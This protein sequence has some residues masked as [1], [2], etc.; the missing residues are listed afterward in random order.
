MFKNYI[1]IAIRNIIKQKLYSFINITGLMVGIA[2]SILIMLYVWQELS[3]DRF[4]TKA[5]QIYRVVIENPHLNSNGE[6]REFKRGTTGTGLALVLKEEFP[7]ILH[8][9]RL[10]PAYP[11]WTFTYNGKMIYEKHRSVMWVDPSFVD[12]FDISWI[13]GDQ[14]TALNEPQSIV[15]TEE[16]AL[17]YFGEED[18]LGKI[19]NLKSGGLSRDYKVT[20]VAKAMPDNSHFNFNFITNDPLWGYDPPFYSWSET[21]TYITLPKGYDPED[22]ETKLPLIVNKYIVP[23]LASNMTMTWDKYVE[24]GVYTKLHLQ[25]LKDIYLGSYFDSYSR[26]G[27]ITY[28][29]IFSTIAFLILFLA[30]VNFMTLSTAR[31]SSRAKEVGVRKILGSSRG[32]LIRQ[33]LSE[34]I[35]NTI[36]A[37]VGALI[38][39]KLFLPAFNN[40]LGM[41]ITP[42]FSEIGLILFTPLAIVIMVGILAGSYPAFFLSVFHPPTFLKGTLPERSR[43]LTLRNSMVVF[44]FIISIV[45][46][47]ASI[48]VYNQL[49]YMRKKDPGYNKK[50]IIIIDNLQEIIKQDHEGMEE[51]RK[52]YYKNYNEMARDKRRMYF[53]LRP[54]TE[55][56]R[57]ELL[58]HSR[59]I[60]ASVLNNLP[61]MWRESRT[62]EFR[63]EELTDYKSIFITWVEQDYCEV[64]DLKFISGNNFASEISTINPETEGIILNEKSVKH[65]DLE[66]PVGKNLIL[67]MSRPIVKEGR[68]IDWEDFDIST[69]VIGV[70]KDFHNMSYKSEIQPIALMP[71]GLGGAY[72]R[73][74]AVKV[75]P[76][77]MEELLAY[78]ENTWNKFVT[79]RPFEYS[80][81]DEDFKNLYT[82][83]ERLGEIFTFFTTLAIFIACLGIFGLAAFNA[84]QRT[85]EIG[86]R[87]VVG[88]SV[89]SIVGLLSIRYIKLIIIANLL[90]WPFAYFAMNKWL[91]NFAYHIDL[92]FAIF[93][94][95][96]LFALFIVL[97]SV[98]SNALK[99]AHANPVDSLKYE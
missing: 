86:I 43:G 74:M 65:L 16:M 84:E 67:K 40:F 37:L 75:T 55:A 97:L 11:D 50:H 1:K 81:F 61:G 41:R 54:R 62:M 69:P 26:R 24:S 45:L 96:G 56:F 99:A 36:L 2:A 44:Q 57:Q 95:T 60:N 77:D 93:G 39:V 88:A 47:V 4:H 27:N 76:G 58:K 32:Q 9:T 28:I 21:G 31:S 5:N 78:M 52:E 42:D 22:L 46:I 90:A 73:R 25:P 6:F 3:F 8:V 68:W 7:E 14:K 71:I 63:Q 15:F 35:L 12:V 33:F 19:V 38:L 53:G 51:E 92:G 23:E 91:Q 59:I 70:V 89:R 85:K 83:E 17:K 98:S 34:S 66:D 64:F 20:G 82:A 72:L 13:L 18:P 79:T 80:F 48:T 30:C 29:Y 10:L 49:S 94:L 87:K